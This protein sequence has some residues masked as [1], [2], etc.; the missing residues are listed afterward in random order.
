[1]K[2][3]LTGF[4]QV[5]LVAIN[6]FFIANKMPIGCAFMG[7]MISFVWSWNVKKVVF[8][9]MK[10]HLIYSFG[11]SIGSVSGLLVSMFLF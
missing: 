2:L 9:T 6:T 7:F 11:A 3:F 10:E 4:L 1:M 8:G 5:F